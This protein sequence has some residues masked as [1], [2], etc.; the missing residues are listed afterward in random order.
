MADLKVN[1]AKVAA[2]PLEVLL[3]NAAT[4][5]GCGVPFTQGVTFSWWLSS[6]SL[7]ALNSSTGSSVAYTACVAPMGGVLH[8]KAALGLTTLYANSTISVSAQASSGQSPPP[9]S[10]GGLPTGVAPSSTTADSWV[11]VGIMVALFAG[12]AAVL[13][14]GRTKRN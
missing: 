4:E 9:T 11:G 13:I 6:V 2:T 14:A 8:V 7:G 3:F 1:P 12:A 10:G 5:N